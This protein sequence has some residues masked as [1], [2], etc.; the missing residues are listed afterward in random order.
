MLKLK[1]TI[2]AHRGAVTSLLI[3]QRRGLLYSGSSDGT[4]AVLSLGTLGYQRRLF[5]FTEKGVNCLSLF[6][7]NSADQSPKVLVGTDDGLYLVNAESN[8]LVRSYR[9]EDQG[10]ETQTMDCRQSGPL[11]YACQTDGAESQFDLYS[12]ALNFQ[13]RGHT[14]VVLAL[15]QIRLENGAEL[16]CSGGEDGKLFFYNH[17]GVALHTIETG[18]SVSCIRFSPHGGVLAVLSLGCLRVFQITDKT[19]L[20]RKTVLLKR[21]LPLPRENQFLH[22]FCFCQRHIFLAGMGR[23]CL[24]DILKGAVVQQFEFP[25]EE[26]ISCASDGKTCACGARGGRT[27]VFELVQ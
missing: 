12:G 25:G 24:I 14:G 1:A 21:E 23:V 13:L 19:R 15:D 20:S 8:K 10:G 7:D 2:T 17:K 27:F 18:A 22:A 26:F 9:P 6:T 11:L 4:V 3:D 16:V 5:G